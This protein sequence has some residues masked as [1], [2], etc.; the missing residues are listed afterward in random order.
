MWSWAHEDIDH[1]TEL[2]EAFGLADTVTE[3][4][5]K[6]K[7]TQKAKPKQEVRDT[8]QS[9]ADGLRIH[10]FTMGRRL[11]QNYLQSPHL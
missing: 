10:L 3:M 11:C 4:P 7:Q 9:A 2:L 6:N 8:W 1:R 5:P